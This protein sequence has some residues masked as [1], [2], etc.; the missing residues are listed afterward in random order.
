VRFSEL[1]LYLGR[2]EETSSR[3]ALVGILAELFG[4]TPSED[5][6]PTC[7]LLQ[8]RLAPFFEPIEIG[9]GQNYVADAVARAYGGDRA[10]VLARFDELGDLGDAAAARAAVSPRAGRPEDAPPVREVFDALLSV[11]RTT[12]VG[13]VSAKVEAFASL[14][15]GLD[16]LSVR[17]LCRIPLGRLRLGIGDPTVLDGFS[18]ARV[19]DR[20]LRK[21]LERA[22]NETSDLGL[23][24]RT[25]W[26]GGVEKVDALG[27]RVGNPVRPALAERLPSAAAI[28]EKLGTCAVEG[29]YDGFRCQVHKSGEEVRVFSRG[30]EDL[31]GIFPEIVEGARRQVSAGEAILE[32]EALAYNPL[33]EEY[34]PFQ[35]T[36]R[37]RRKHGV[38]EAAKELPL[39]LFAFD[40]LYT[41]GERVMDRPYTE[42]R[43]LLGQMVSDGEIVLVSESR[44]AERAKDLEAIFEESVQGGLE[45]VVAKRPDSPYQAGARNYNWVK[46]KRVQAGYL[47]DTVDCVIVGYL[48]GRGRRAAFGVGALL[49]AVYDE[50]R[51][52][53]PTVTKIGTG[54]SDKQWQEVR[55]RCE[56]FV[57]ES[58][59]ARVES[60]VEPS[61]WVEPKVVI[62]VLADEIT[63]SPVHAAGRSAEGGQGYALRF[64]RLVS[65]RDADKRP[66]DATTVS[67]IVELYDQQDARP[68]PG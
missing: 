12:G 33:S 39:R 40:V 32:G 15:A 55:E 19:G 29:K 22:Y 45:G 4:R 68:A 9:L 38:E 48:Y 60:D 62:E 31:T 23:V 43:A 34:L 64:P 58:K 16:P 47:E 51:D 46:L 6:A 35:Q 59:P 20:S 53:F 41:D 37:R 8:S 3:N 5:V 13:S 26:E 10:R 7:Y 57:Q 52:V 2:L 50:G 61:V 30:L 24:G 11:S 27:V 63:R 56:P 17:Y 66:E 21:R 44:T 65:F 25:L 36:V 28:L 67:E 18:F 14:L 54:L 49:V 1:A 42:R